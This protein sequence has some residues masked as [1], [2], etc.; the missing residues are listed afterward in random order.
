MNNLR[1]FL[2]FF[3]ISSLFMFGFWINFASFT[4]II[5]LAGILL[6]LFFL[7]SRKGRIV[8][9]KELKLVYSEFAILVVGIFVVTSISIAKGHSLT[10]CILGSR[11]Y[12]EFML[13]GFMIR[14]LLPDEG[15]HSRFIDFLT[16]FSVVMCSFGIAQF[17]FNK[18]LPD[19]LLHVRSDRIDYVYGLST[20]LF[21]INALY[22]NSIVFDGII[23]IST[24]LSFSAILIKGKSVFRY[25]CFV[26]TIIANILTFSRASIVGSVMVYAVLYIL[27]GKRGRFDKYIR[28][29]A[30][31][32]LGLFSFLTFA[33]GTAVYQRLFNS[34]VT[35]DSDVVHRTTI[36]EAQKVISDNL[37]FG[38]G[39]GTQGYDSTDSTV[40][41]IRDGCWMQFALEL[42]LPL[43]VLYVCILLTLVFI[44][45]KC[46]KK[47]N[48]DSCKIACS[49]FVS[50]TLYFS[51]ASF[52]NSAY[53]AKEV[54]GLFWVLAGTMLW[55]LQSVSD[56]T[57]NYVT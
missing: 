21:R 30:I 54:F 32:A 8:F 50:I 47:S 35:A 57:A 17:V 25:V 45:L 18:A 14:A 9:P 43:T 56:N 1:K 24:A 2:L 42:G 41:V 19:Q 36:I 26:I 23:I 48:N 3:Y 55:S 53:N 22:E 44:S 46:L 31:S 10:M 38:V 13:L 16:V 51:V 34:T 7:I 33:S 6:F 12:L 37:L 39:M 27:L 20:L 40:G 4:L 15:E 29:I 5:D 49:V 11:D 52:I 28:L